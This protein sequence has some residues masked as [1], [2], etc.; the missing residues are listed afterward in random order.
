MDR[1]KLA[2]N[3]SLVIC[4]VIFSFFRIYSLFYSFL[5]K[6]EEWAYTG[7]FEE[8]NS[9]TNILWVVLIIIPIVLAISVCLLIQNLEKKFKISMNEANKEKYVKKLLPVTII[10]VILTIAFSLIYFIREHTF[11]EYISKYFGTITALGYD[12]LDWAIFNFIMTAIFLG[13]AL[14]IYLYIFRGFDQEQYKGLAIGF[15]FIALIVL[16]VCVIISL[17]LFKWINTFT[18]ETWFA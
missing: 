3:I 7:N 8:M 18:I 2:L 4:S 5:R 16:T 9:I 10:I 12:L 17:F 14:G 13:F 15:V 1:R 6:L 11:M